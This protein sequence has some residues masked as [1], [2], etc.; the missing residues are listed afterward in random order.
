MEILSPEITYNTDYQ[1]QEISFNDLLL[2]LY[3]GCKSSD[4][5]V[6]FIQAMQNR[7][8]LSG[9]AMTAVDNVT[10]Q[11]SKT[12]ICG[13][14]ESLLE[15]YLEE[16]RMYRDPMRL[17]LQKQHL[18][19]FDV[20]SIEEPGKTLDEVLDLGEFNHVAETR[21][22]FDLAGLHIYSSANESMGLYLHRNATV[23]AF[24][25]DQAEELHQLV[26]HIRQAME[27]Y[28]G[29]YEKSVEAMGLAQALESIESPLLI[30]NQFLRVCFVNRPA[31]TLVNTCDQMHITDQTLS[32]SEP[33]YQQQLARY[34]QSV[35][36]DNVS[37]AA[38]PMI[39]VLRPGKPS[40]RLALSPISTGADDERAHCL[41]LQVLPPNNDESPEW[42]CISEKMGL[43]KA[44]ARVCEAL[45]DGLSIKDIANKLNRQES[46][47]RSNL[48]SA[49]SKTGH[50]S[51]SQLVAAIYR[52][53]R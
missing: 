6:D 34:M 46:T 5:F 22:M 9:V 20:L 39:T 30:V 8:N 31:K 17:R 14:P 52:C 50:H 32:F 41:M 37:I 10:H 49:F 23:G 27:L 53:C 1:P 13:I 12:W 7:Y 48:K 4:G 44:E 28:R 21:D 24:S 25:P 36:T 18:D 51:Q 33:E 45:C 15:W 11:L 3:Q 40:F 43:S 16:D 19:R 47:V 35:F 26:P 29:L 38:P 42:Q 2:A